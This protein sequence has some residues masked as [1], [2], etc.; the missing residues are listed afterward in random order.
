MLFKNRHKP[1]PHVAAIIVAAG[2]GSRMGAD[3]PK[4]FIDVNGRPILAYTLD[5]FQNCQKID[6]II[7][8]TRSDSIVLCKSIVDTYGFSKVSVIT[9]GGSTR[10]QSVMLG[11]AQMSSDDGYVL[12]HDGARP[13][14]SID[15]IEKCIDSVFENNASAVGVPMK[16]TI[17]YSDDGKFIT[18]TVDRSRLW[19]I[20]TP[21]AFEKQL[22]KQ[23]HEKAASEA[24]DATDDCM[25]AEHFGIKVA[26]V[27][28][29]YENIKITSPSDIYVMEGLLGV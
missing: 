19:L 20:Q 12:I 14:I 1:K 11:I 24:F 18:K 27:E 16:D 2:S 5:K 17:K 6:E 3:I 26:I 7:I 15:T 21:Q 9:E 28:G 22:I 23:C 10:Q 13:L 4:Q 8:V 29:E 25:L